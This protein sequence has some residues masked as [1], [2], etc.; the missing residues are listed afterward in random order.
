M[1]QMD[2]YGILYLQVINTI[3]PSSKYELGLFFYMYGS[4]HNRFS[5]DYSCYKPN[6][7]DLETAIQTIHL[8][9]LH[10]AQS[11]LPSN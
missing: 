10:N 2:H 1:I 8:Y 5:N 4:V 9:P 7:N 3:N 6:G 11:F